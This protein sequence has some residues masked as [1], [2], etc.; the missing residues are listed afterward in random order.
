MV[1][2]VTPAVSTQECPKRLQAL[3]SRGCKAVLAAA[4]SHNDAVDGR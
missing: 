4:L 3:G 1:L 2:I